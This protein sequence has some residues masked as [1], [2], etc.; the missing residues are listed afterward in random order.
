MSKLI[1]FFQLRLMYEC[2]PM[3]FIIEEAGGLATT[4]KIS[5][6]DVIPKGI[7]QRSPCFLG[8]KEDIKELLGIIGKHQ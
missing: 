7:H 2:N 5:I 1:Y 3:A 4:G 6:L 8:S